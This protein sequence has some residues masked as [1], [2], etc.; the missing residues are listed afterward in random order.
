MNLIAKSCL[1]DLFR[2]R[3]VK[4]PCFCTIATSVCIPGFPQHSNTAL[5]HNMV[6]QS[7]ILC[8]IVVVQNSRERSPCVAVANTCL[9]HTKIMFF[10]SMSSS[11]PPCLLPLMCCVSVVFPSGYDLSGSQRSYSTRGWLNWAF[12]HWRSHKLR[13]PYLSCHLINPTTR[14]QRGVANLVLPP[15]N[16]QIPQRMAHQVRRMSYIHWPKRI[17]SILFHFIQPP[18]GSWG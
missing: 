1:I 17:Y 14:E 8:Y 3:S 7:T 12:R 5:F 2:R 18:K 6:A 16:V 13:V 10:L 9:S 15:V 11:W 4:G